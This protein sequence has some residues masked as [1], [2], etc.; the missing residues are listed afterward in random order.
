MTK[1]KKSKKKRIILTVIVIALI[2]IIFGSIIIRNA[3]INQEAKEESRLAGANQNS[4]LIANNIK[5]GV[6]IGG[7]TGTLE[8]LDT[9]DAT[10]TAEDILNGET[11]YV[12]GSKIT[13][14]FVPLDTSDATATAQD[15]LSGK[16]AYV[17]GNKIT[18]LLQPGSQMSTGRVTI[19]NDYEDINCGFQAK[20]VIAYSYISYY[21]LMVVIYNNG[22]GCAGYVSVRSSDYINVADV[23]NYITPLPNGFRFTSDEGDSYPIV[24]EDREFIYL[25]FS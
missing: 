21:S 7:I 8:S 16:T 9:S 23:G 13:G 22:S 10:A 2:G 3:I 19:G 1:V 15:I 24:P 18:G 17:N 20:Y 6:T 25:A 4:E 11:A 14:T 12:K 5:K